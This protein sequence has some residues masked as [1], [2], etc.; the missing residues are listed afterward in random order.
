MNL[1][2]MGKPGAGKGTQAKKILRHY[3]LAHISTG[4]IYRE[5]MRKESPIGLIAKQY[6]SRGELVP[7]DM[8]N[9]IVEEVL[10]THKYP[11][12]FMLDGYPRTRAQAEA[13]DCNLA[14]LGLKLTAVINVDINDEVLMHRM[15]GRR[16]CPNCQATYHVAN[17]PPQVP[18]ICDVCGH[19]LIQREDDKE[20]SVLNRLRI[21]NKMT[22]P[23]IDYYR[24]KGLL[25]VVDGD[26]PVNTV[27]KEICK[28]IEEK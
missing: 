27:F 6:V 22:K 5:E 9:D 21:Y 10:H 1:L 15:A 8:T 26:L 28:G 24:E 13:L 4:D 7:D 23:L 19:E 16:V 17:H 11:N 20:T 3:H 14:R 25:L 12:G 18:G 2:I